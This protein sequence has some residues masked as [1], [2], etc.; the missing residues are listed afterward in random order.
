MRVV[1]ADP[2]TLSRFRVQGREPKLV[3]VVTVD[4]AYFQCSRA[5]VR[6]NLWTAERHIVR[7]SLPTPGKVLSDATAG[8][9]D[10]GV[11]DQELP[12]RIKSTLY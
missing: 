3:L 7:G 8:K 2:A 12:G 4:A 5:V 6:S 10:G 1:N 11:Y 9:I